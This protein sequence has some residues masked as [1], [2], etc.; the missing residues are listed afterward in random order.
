[1]KTT[2]I[3]KIGVRFFV[4][5][6]IVGIILSFLAIYLF[7]EGEVYI[8]GEINKSILGFIVWGSTAI[9]CVTDCYLYFKKA[10]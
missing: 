5:A 2:K 4:D 10:G 6:I 7:P 8:N 3:L 9:I 1:M